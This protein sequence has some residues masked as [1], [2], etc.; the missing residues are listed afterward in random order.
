[1]IEID[2]TRKDGTIVR[3]GTA[4]RFITCGC[5][6]YAVGTF[7]GLKDGW[8]VGILCAILAAL[9]TVTFYWMDEIEF[10]R[11]SDNMLDGVRKITEVIKEVKKIND[12]TLEMVRT[13]NDR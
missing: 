5:S 7:N 8:I 10:N 12:E 4:L 2:L 9:I 3:I 11:R 13:K 1:M 6:C